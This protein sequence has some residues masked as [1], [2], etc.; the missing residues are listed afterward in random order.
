MRPWFGAPLYVS[1]AQSVFDAEGRLIDADIR[2]QLEVLLRE[3]AR[4]LD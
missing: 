3:F 4:A 2:L 1:G